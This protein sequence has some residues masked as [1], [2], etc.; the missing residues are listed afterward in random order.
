MDESILQYAA[1]VVDVGGCFKSDH[2]YKVL[3]VNCAKK[4]GDMSTFLV[5]KFGGKISETASAWIWNKRGDELIEFLKMILPHMLVQKHI[6]E[7]FINDDISNLKELKTEIKDVD[8]SIVPSI[9]WRAGIIDIVSNFKLEKTSLCLTM[10]QTNP[11]VLKLFERLY[12]G[13]FSYVQS[14]KSYR[15]QTKTFSRIILNDVLPYSIAK[16]DEMLKSSKTLRS[17][18]T[19][20][21]REYVV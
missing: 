5:E 6:A 11:T 20:C 13:N 9:P 17:L 10:S 19:N 2:G 3:L 16:K 21:L 12:H 18:M 4:K 7:M 8:D 14:D 1:G 15:F